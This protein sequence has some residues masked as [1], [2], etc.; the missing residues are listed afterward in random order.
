[1]QIRD[2]VP[3]LPD[4]TNGD[5]RPECDRC[6]RGRRYRRPRPAEGAREW[7]A[8]PLVPEWLAIRCR[9]PRRSWGRARIPT[10]ISQR[11]AIGCWRLSASG[12]RSSTS[13]PTR[14]CSTGAGTRC[15]SMYYRR[16]WARR[17]PGDIRLAVARMATMIDDSHAYVAESP[18]DEPL[19]G[20]GYP[21]IR[22]RVIEG[23]PVVTALWDTAA[24]LAAGVR[25]G[26]VIVE[27]D[28]EPAQQRLRQAG[29]LLSSSTPQS[30][31]DRAALSFMNG[32]PGSTVRLSAAKPGCH[33]ESDRAR[34]EARGLHHALPVTSA[35]AMS[36]GCC[37]GTSATSI[38]TG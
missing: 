17:V 33:G 8:R 25:V 1:M 20:D 5:L 10:W 31:L 19:I 27:V 2:A 32:G 34:A 37:R 18:S 7:R 30:R 23:S 38:S 36:R 4:G 12:T 3:V 16:F 21:P 22:V 11:S 6:A 9:S 24:A 13:I 28:D 15:S 35:M 14:P 26:Q 29:S